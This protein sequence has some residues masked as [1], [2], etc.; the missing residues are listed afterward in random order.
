MESSMNRV[1]PP[2][3][4]CK[5]SYLFPWRKREAPLLIICTYVF[6]FFPPLILSLVSP[7]TR[8]ARPA[9]EQEL[10][11]LKAVA[12][13]WLA[14]SGSLKPANEF[15]A[16]TKCSAFKP[17]P[18]RFKTEAMNMSTVKESSSSSSC[19]DFSE[20]LLDSY[21]IVT[22]AKRLEAS[23]AMDHPMSG[24]LD[25]VQNI[26]KRRRIESKN[27]LRNLFGKMSSKR[28][29]ASVVPRDEYWD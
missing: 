20:S 4:P 29:D 10:E 15:D 5:N 2:I 7:M 21:E 14:H 17:R 22:L 19:W 16:Q 26:G 28:F 11:L 9:D 12:Q 27:S 1:W 25:I 24:P 3:I 8:I 13:A 23:L 18:S 6:S